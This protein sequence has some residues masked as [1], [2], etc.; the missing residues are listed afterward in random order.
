MNTRPDSPSAQLAR[1]L[2]ELGGKMIPDM[3]GGCIVVVRR[4]AIEIQGIGTVPD[5]EL[6]KS[7]RALADEVDR[8]ASRIAIVGRS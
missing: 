6:A 3:V 4:N 8:R 1:V 5:R 7:L 2:A